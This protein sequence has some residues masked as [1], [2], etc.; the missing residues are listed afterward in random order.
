[1]SASFR[2]EDVTECCRCGAAELHSM[3]MI[4]YVGGVVSQDRGHQDPHTHVCTTACVT[5]N[6][7]IVPLVAQ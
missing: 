4:S 5:P 7:A 3:P 2:D 1:M 6:Y